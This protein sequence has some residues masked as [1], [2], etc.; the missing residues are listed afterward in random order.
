MPDMFHG[1]SYCTAESGLLDCPFMFVSGSHMNAY[2][3]RRKCSS[4]LK[5]IEVYLLTKIR[6]KTQYIIKM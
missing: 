5:L 6:V 4:I 2:T 1:F 3:V